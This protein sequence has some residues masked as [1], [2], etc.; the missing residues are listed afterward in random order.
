MAR[1][2]EWVVVPGTPVPTPWSK[3]AFE[4]Q[5]R[6]IQKRRREIRAQ[7]LKSS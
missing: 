6:E 4:T 1:A 3:E 2:V 5:S 7:N